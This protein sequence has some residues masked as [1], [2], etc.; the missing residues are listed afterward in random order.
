[1]TLRQP[2]SFLRKRNLKD[3]KEFPKCFLFQLHNDTFTD[4]DRMLAVMYRNIDVY[5]IPVSINK[6]IAT[7]FFFTLLWGG[8]SFTIYVSL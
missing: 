7:K 1:M 5:N 3:G 2:S 6:Q 4:V 8:Q